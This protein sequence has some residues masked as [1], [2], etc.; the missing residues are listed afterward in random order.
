MNDDQKKASDSNQLKAHLSSYGAGRIATV[1]A[2]LG[3]VV[4]LTR[5]DSQLYLEYSLILAAVLFANSLSFGWLRQAMLRD[6]GPSPN[7]NATWPDITFLGT[8]AVGAA[9]TLLASGMLVSLSGRELLAVALFSVS[10]TC[11]QYFSTQAQSALRPL[12]SVRIEAVRLGLLAL[13]PL[14]FDAMDLDVGL[15]NVL[16]VACMANITAIAPELLTARMGAERSFGRDLSFGFPIALWLSLSTLLQF[17]DRWIVAQRVTAEAASSYAVTY[18]LITRGAGTLLA[19][20]II[21]VHPLIMS[22]ANDS[23]SARVRDLMGRAGRYAAVASL[24]VVVGAIAFSIG[25]KYIV[26]GAVTAIPVVMILAASGVSWQLVLI[27]HKQYEVRRQTWRMLLC[28]ILSLGYNVTFN[29]VF[30]PIFGLAGVAAANLTA[31]LL[32]LLLLFGLPDKDAKTI[33][34][35]RRP[36]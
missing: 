6:A 18:D 29:W 5:I 14:A 9:I 12:R 15:E 3:I 31:V 17:S 35:R 33:L 25:G 23:S 11:G 36:W 10:Y 13:V 2:Q 21:A 30:A 16:L 1:V 4:V 20:L 22:A 24:A 32:Y 34:V 26:P 28:L 7:S 8:L 27:A 19:P